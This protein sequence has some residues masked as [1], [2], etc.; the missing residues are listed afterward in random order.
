MNKKIVVLLIEDDDGHAKLVKRGFR[1]QEDRYLL[2]VATCLEDAMDYLSRICPDIVIS[3]LRLPDGNGT[4]IMADTNNID[5]F[6]LVVMTSF[7]DERIAVNAMKAGALDYI[8]KTPEALKAMPHIVQRILREWG[9]IVRRK[10]AESE[11]RSYNERLEESVTART[12]DLQKSYQKL[13]MEILER[14]RV[15][16]ELKKY[17]SQLEE[18]VEERTKQL[19][20]ANKKLERLANFDALTGVAN[21]RNFIETLEKEWKRSIRSKQSLALIMI[22]IDFFKAY[23][24]SYGHPAGDDCLIRVASNLQNAL[25]RTGDLLARYGGEE[26]VVIL[27]GTEL[28]GAALVAEKLRKSI[29][30]V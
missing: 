28:K 17:R 2:E 6:P 20:E 12:D 27:P 10:Q 3:D 5:R 22:D 4:D 29:E 1:D 18:L 8:V 21:R 19:A 30:A 14:K 26:F 13:L 11:L 23:N 15:E 16:E 7:G 25:V 9:H 24:D